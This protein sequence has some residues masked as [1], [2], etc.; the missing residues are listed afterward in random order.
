MCGSEQQWQVSICQADVV[1]R[2]NAAFR[3]TVMETNYNTTLLTS[4]PENQP[5]VSDSAQSLICDDLRRV[6]T[7]KSGEER[8]RDAPAR[9]GVLLQRTIDVTQS[10]TTWAMLDQAIYSGTTFCTSVLLGRLAGADALGVYSLAFSVTI[11]VLCGHETLVTMPYTINVHQLQPNEQGKAAGSVFIFY[12]AFSF[13]AGFAFLVAGSVLV[14]FAGR[15]TL[16]LVLLSVAAAIPGILLRELARKLAYAHLH[17]RIAFLLDAAA[18]LVQLSTLFLLVT[19]DLL[20]ASTAFAA[21]GLGSCIAGLG[22][23]SFSRHRFSFSVRQINDDLSRHLRIGRWIC[24]ALVTLLLQGSIAMWLIAYVLGTAASGVFAACMS[25]IALSNPLINAI[26]N[27]F[28]P[29]ACKVLNESGV[30]GLW[31]LA[32]SKVTVL[33]TVAGLFACFVVLFGDAFVH[34]F[35]GPNYAE[36][37]AMIICLAFV[38]FAK[39]I[40]TIAYNGL[41]VL[42]WFSI[43]LWINLCS[44]AVLVALMVPLMAATGVTGAAAALLTVSSLACVVR[45]AVFTKAMKLAVRTSPFVH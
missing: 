22:W 9:F 16:G 36:E 38:S 24:L 44:L 15:S 29:E 7:S 41:F 32:Q 6:S 34:F 37:R 28:I 12:L 3:E 25:V 23:L 30:E 13:L 20:S 40:E 33:A 18:S 42:K 31:R 45:W 19:Y 14:E 4:E 39:A 17:I 5:V 43:N 21:V 8:C 26:G 10:P 2:M 1:P 11:L 35:Y 27:V